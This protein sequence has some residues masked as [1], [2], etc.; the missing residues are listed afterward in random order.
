MTYDSDKR[1]AFDPEHKRPKRI[2]MQDA[3][4]WNF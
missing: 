3:I 4:F 1:V 2:F